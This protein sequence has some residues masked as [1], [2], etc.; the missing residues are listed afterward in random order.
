MSEEDYASS[1]KKKFRWEDTHQTDGG[2]SGGPSNLPSSTRWSSATPRQ[3]GASGSSTSS[4]AGISSVALAATGS[5]IDLSHST[6][7]GGSGGTGLMYEGGWRGFATPSATPI[8]GDE[9][10][11][12]RFGSGSADSSFFINT[13]GGMMFSGQN[14]LISSGRQTPS[15]M[16]GG[17]KTPRGGSF[18]GGALGATPAFIGQ[19]PRGGVGAGGGQGIGGSYGATPSFNFEGTT[20]VQSH[21]VPGGMLATPS[22]VH[23]ACTPTAGGGLSDEGHAI[24]MTNLV[25][26]KAREFEKEWRLKNRRLT[27]EFLDELLP[28]DGYFEK[29][30][31][32]ADYNPMLPDEPNFFEMAI[33]E[34]SRNGPPP[35]SFVSEDGKPFTYDIPESL[36]FGMPTMTPAD[37][38]VF[39]ELLQYAGKEECIPPEGL[40]S[41]MLMKHLFKIKNGDAQQRRSATRYLLSKSSVFGASLIFSRLFT[42]WTHCSAAN[43]LDLSQKH[44]LIEFCK[45][46]ITKLDVSVRSSCKEVVHLMQPLLSVP[47][48]IIRED[49]KQT[50][51][52]LTRIA[53]FQAVWSAIQSDFSHEDNSIRRHTAK[54]VALMAAASGM[55][56]IIEALKLQ[57]YSLSL[58]ARQTTARAIG[59]TCGVLGHA[60]V[61]GLSE[62][63][64]ILERLLR[65]DRR[66]AREAAV[67]VSM[68][69]EACAPY[70]R[71]ELSAV[72]YIIG[73][74][75][76]KN[77][78]NTAAPFL[79]AFA[80]LLPLMAPEEAKTRIAA[81]IPILVNQF[82]TPE[83]E[84]RRTLLA[85]VRR[86]VTADGITG[87]FIREF[88]LEPFF[89]GFWK[90][91][92]V[93][94]DRKS[95]GLLVAATVDIAKKT[96]GV[97]VLIPLSKDMNN[98][99]ELFQHLVMYAVRRVIHTVGMEDVSS[100]L[101][102]SIIEKAISAVQQDEL[103]TNKV[104]LDALIAICN[105]L[106]TRLKPFLKDIFGVIHS[107]RENREAE[108][109]TQAA[110]FTARIA[111]TVAK[112]DGAIF[113]QDLSASL[114]TR[115][116]D[117]SPLVLSAI[118]HATRVLLDILGSAKYR[119]S[120]R[121]LLR[122]LTFVIK[123]PNSMVQQNAIMLIEVIA[124]QYDSEVEP[125][126][127]HQLATRGLFEL[128]DAD[129]RETRRTC[130][131]TFGAIASKL[132][133]FAIIAELVDNFRQD[134]RKIRIC[135]AV[136]LSSIAKSCGPFTVLP[137]ILNEFQ[138]S[139]N[140]QVAVI[141]QHSVL[142][143]IRYVF[144]AIGP[145]GEDYVFVCLPLLQRALTETS[146][147]MRRM[148][149]EAARAILMAVAGL[150]GFDKVTI[151]LLNFVHPNIV[152]LLSRKQVTVAEERRKLITAVVSFYEAARLHVGPGLLYYAYL[153]QGLFH[154]SKL[155]RDIYRRT[156]NI[157]YLASPEG[158]V[159]HYPLI[160]DGPA[161]PAV[162]SEI[163]GNESLV[164]PP[165]KRLCR[166]EVQVPF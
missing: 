128:L 144:E 159:L 33:Q 113:L 123:N 4:G 139:E 80:S 36:G 3:L 65:D 166:Y 136:A 163:L 31:P 29:V 127:L 97:E 116:E 78:G 58:S 28:S 75:C 12:P 55:E 45:A 18:T 16:A 7:R 61:T 95:S 135:T 10:S 102:R 141:V 53:G 68:I 72:I 157:I 154:P 27:T 71:K 155:V 39:V 134:K 42:I 13:P 87:D 30:D 85:V 41:Y 96:G 109:R 88:V 149:I 74:E 142:K 57:S 25:E 8:G 2:N 15:Q 70:G 120:V 64:S 37:A 160:E 111:R 49:G 40:L 67:A 93:A 148:A 90:V 47:E 89:D 129:R 138:V 98:D 133:P 103:G 86:C 54:V 99:N 81:M 105:A 143:A 106:G 130:A 9:I 91:Q 146:I 26:K 110:E 100:A 132:S 125:L 44:F 52:L 165:V 69:A 38:P 20:P 59:E 150:D 11:T 114:Y 17:Q 6:P 107:R 118:L 22:G 63:V 140:E 60:M 51:I 94:V 117:D 82:H 92:R 43:T 151:H 76:R 119:P 24:N 152:E 112:A 19:T 48:E 66:V 84:Y 77:H 46:L 21:Y 145:D 156:Y 121:E 122:K 147:Q 101:S 14:S 162:Q 115:M 5:V 23:L 131:R 35:M 164:K 32:P 158:L 126:H 62:M 104:S 56:E 153:S 34:L 108:V 73:E 79:R 124:T 50:L 161:F 83:D 1:T 137:Y